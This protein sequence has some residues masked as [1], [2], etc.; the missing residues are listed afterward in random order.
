MVDPDQSTGL[1][2]VHSLCGKGFSTLTGVKKHH[3][4]KKANDLA[5]TTGCWAKHNKPD[6]AWDD[7]PS[8]KGGRST[9][10]VAKTAPPTRK[11]RQTK[12]SLSQS[13]S[14]S[15]IDVP[16]FQLLPGFPI[17]DDLPRTVAKAV[18]A[19]NAPGSSTQEMM[20]QTP[21]FASRSG[22]DSLLTA[23]N[24]VSQIDA[25]KPKGR[26]DSIAQN[27]DAQVAAAEQRLSVGAYESSKSSFNVGP[28]RAIAPAALEV[29]GSSWTGQPLDNISGHYLH[30]M[31]EHSSV[32]PSDIEKSY[33]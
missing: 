5:T 32:L 11:Q 7:H 31:S 6:V 4:G 30:S 12:H 25:P 17:L 27:L 8:C 15:P 20:H 19:G 21:R 9:S 18:H 16:Q 3:W 2:Y 23:V 10:V 28:Y 22:F 29:T 24:V 14:P 13:T 26:A 33:A 1:P